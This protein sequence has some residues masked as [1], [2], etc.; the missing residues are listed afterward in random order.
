[1]NLKH[2]RTIIIN[3]HFNYFLIFINLINYLYHKNNHKTYVII[4]D[5]ILIMLL[6]YFILF[7]I[8]LFYCIIWHI[9]IIVRIFHITLFLLFIFFMFL[10]YFV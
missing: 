7:Y 6:L 1:M 2:E 10:F 9:F 5:N 8:L 4:Y 3:K